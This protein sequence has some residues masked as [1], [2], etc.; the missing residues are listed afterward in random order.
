MG[1]VII[2]HF[3]RVLEN[4]KIIFNDEA[5]WENQRLSLRGKDFELVITE[6]IK[7]PSPDQFG[8]L[9]GGILGSML[10]CNQFSHYDSPK[11]LCEDLLE[12]M[13]L[14]YQVLVRVGKKSWLQTKTRRL[15]DLSKK[16]LS[17]FIE[18]VLTYCGREGIEIL[19]SE[20]YVNKY[21]KEIT[22]KE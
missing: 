13:F 6:K 12:P 4:G 15:S 9:F 17:E 7:K 10:T 11:E 22:I 3:G 16:E 18:K 20:Q 21:Y 5:M 8:Y 19:E 1:K 2:R 14:S